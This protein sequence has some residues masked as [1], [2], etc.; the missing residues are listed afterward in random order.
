AMGEGRATPGEAPPERFDTGLLR[1]DAD[2]AALAD[3]L[4]APGA[5]RD[6]SLLLS[7]PPGTG[8]SAYVRHLAERMGLPVLQRRASDLLGRYVGETEQRIAAAFSEAAAARAFL[9]FD[10]ADSL[11]GAREGAQ[12]S[13]Q[14]S[15]VNEMLTWME[16]HDWPLA[17]TTN[18]AEHLD[19][20]VMRRVLLKL[21]FDHLTPAQAAAAF[22]S[23]FGLEPPPGLAALDRLTPADFAVVRRV[24]ALQGG[25]DDAAALLAAL[26][27][28]QQAKPGAARAIGFR[29]GA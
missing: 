24:A 8:K 1:A 2:L 27:R 3:R 23:F 17:F 29:A 26:V 6:V 19:P 28:E 13:W 15:Q 4:A 12:Q 5:P 20:A 9:V 22:R 16:R 14:V 7:G 21:R 11:L 18:F 10:E 25:L